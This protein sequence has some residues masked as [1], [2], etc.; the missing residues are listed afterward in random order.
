MA[1]VGNIQAT[2]VAT[3]EVNL[4]MVFSEYCPNPALSKLSVS[5]GRY[6]FYL[7]PYQGFVT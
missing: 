6:N 5:L 7:E 1:T 3:E 4:S 2:T